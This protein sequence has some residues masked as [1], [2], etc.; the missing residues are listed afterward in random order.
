MMGNALVVDQGIDNLVKDVAN[1]LQ[2]N[3][4]EYKQ[5]LQRT[6]KGNE[7]ERQL[8]TILVKTALENIDE[9]NP[10][11][12]YVASRFYL[13]QLYR[14][15]AKHRNGDKTSPYQNFYG[16]I[17]YLTKIGIYTPALMEKYSR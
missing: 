4:E 14:E 16:L 8:T 3:L 15:A 12:T 1:G 11:W 9:A 17:E 13:K 5:K 7:T 10:D 2:V 6:I